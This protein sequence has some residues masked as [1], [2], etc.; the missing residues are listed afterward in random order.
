M[1]KL[2]QVNEF[3]LQVRQTEYQLSKLET[4]LYQISAISKDLKGS[5]LWLVRSP[6][7]QFGLVLGIEGQSLRLNWPWQNIP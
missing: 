6:F 2:P 3:S 5:F 7:L 4:S 1:L